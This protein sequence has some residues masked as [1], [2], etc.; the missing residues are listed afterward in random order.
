MEIEKDRETGATNIY[1]SSKE[2]VDLVVALD[3]LK[4]NDPVL[5]EL[6]NKLWNG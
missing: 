3:K 1:L 2:T 5:K 6:M 4:S